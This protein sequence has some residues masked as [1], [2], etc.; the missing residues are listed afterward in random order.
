M[1]FAAGLTVSG[2]V[3][4]I[5]LEALKLL[6]PAVTAWVLGLLAIALKILLVGIG[7]ALAVA[8]IGVA[9]FLYKRSERSRAEA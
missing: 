6:M 2:I 5:I 9:I 7:L 1:K 3:G 8:A 4:F